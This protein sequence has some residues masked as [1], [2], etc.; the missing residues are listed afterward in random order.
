MSGLTDRSAALMR[1]AGA[2]H[3]VYRCYDVEGLLLYIGCSSD[4][5]RRIKKHFTASANNTASWWLSL[6]YA[7]HDFEGPFDGRDTG[8]A[9]ES[10]AIEAERPLFNLQG[11]GIRHQRLNRVAMY[12]VE[13]GERTLAIDTACICR[14]EWII[15]RKYCRAHF[16]QHEAVA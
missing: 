6:F 5:E 15:Q 13:H 2:D 9:V 11:N 7:R 14:S 16:Y 1:S 12:L 8:R 4:V 10:A 3:Y